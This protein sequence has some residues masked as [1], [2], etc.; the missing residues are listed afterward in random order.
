MKEESL[1]RKL[2]T[3]FYLRLLNAPA[4]FLSGHILA[5][6]GKYIKFT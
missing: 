1:S 4:A 6:C 2:R 3:G 5:Y